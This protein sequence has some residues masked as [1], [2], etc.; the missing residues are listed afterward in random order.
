MTTHPAATDPIASVLPLATHAA[1]IAAPMAMVLIMHLPLLLNGFGTGWPPGM[2]MGPGNSG[3]FFG[4]LMRFILNPSALISP[5][6]VFG[7]DKS[8]PPN[9]ASLINSSQ[10]T[11]V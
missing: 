1:T 6:M 7:S 10:S 3:H 2:G 5:I 8:S 9:E 4:H 11:C